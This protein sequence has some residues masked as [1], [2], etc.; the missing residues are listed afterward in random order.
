MGCLLSWPYKWRAPLPQQR[1]KNGLR[2]VNSSFGREPWS[3]ILD[4][5]LLLAGSWPEVYMHLYVTWDRQSSNEANDEATVRGK[6]SQG[7]KRPRESQFLRRTRS[8]MAKCECPGTLY[9]Q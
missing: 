7:W 9:I 2:H 6:R 5:W 4:L 3:S 1:R 8:Q